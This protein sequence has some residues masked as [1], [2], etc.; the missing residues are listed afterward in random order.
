MCNTELLSEVLQVRPYKSKVDGDSHFLLPMVTLLLMQSRAQLAFRAASTHY[1]FMLNFSP[2]NTSNSFSSG[3]L[4]IHSLPSCFCVWDCPK[5]FP[6]LSFIRILSAYFSC[7][8]WLPWEALHSGLSATPPVLYCLWNYWRY[9]IT[10]PKSLMKPF[11]STELSRELWNIPRMTCFYLD[12]PRRKLR[13][14]TLFRTLPAGSVPS[15][16]F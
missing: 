5:P 12:L 9:T 15:R 16:L 11:N 4:L 6:S 2:T 8:S 1:Q 10:L 7:L 3:L 14:R 13:L